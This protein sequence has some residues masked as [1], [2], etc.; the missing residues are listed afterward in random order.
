MHVVYDTSYDTP[1]VSSLTF[2]RGA[3]KIMSKELKARN[4]LVM[5]FR[6]VVCKAIYKNS[7]IKGSQ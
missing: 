3:N 1:I 5:Q 2:D 6:Q 7:E 4:N